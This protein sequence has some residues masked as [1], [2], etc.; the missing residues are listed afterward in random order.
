[1]EENVKKIMTTNDKFEF[2]YISKNMIQSFLEKNLQNTLT[3]IL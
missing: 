1:M 2:E 3:K